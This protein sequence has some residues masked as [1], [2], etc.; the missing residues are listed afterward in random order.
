MSWVIANSVAAG[1]LA[2]LVLLVGRLLRPAPAVMHVLWLFVLL[3][4]ITPPLFEVPINVSWLPGGRVPPVVVPLELDDAMRALPSVA[5]PTAALLSANV[6]PAAATA[7][8]WS[9]ALRL[10]WLIGSV[11]FLGVLAL[12]V[13][14]GR[15]RL[16]ALGPVS[17][18]LQREVEAL[19]QQLG[20]RVPEV[21]D[22]PAAASPCVWSLGRVRLVLPA[23]VLATSSPKGRAAVL[24]HELAHLRRGDHWIAHAELL[25]AVVLWWHPLFWFARSRLRHEAELACDAWAV[26]SVP[27]ATIDYAAVLIETVARPDSAVPGLTVLAAR[28]AARAAFERRLTMIL[29]ENVPCRASRAWW[30]PFASL[31]LG[32]FAVPVVAQQEAKPELRIEVR[33]NGKDVG[34]L[35]AAERRALLQRLL[36]DEAAEAKSAKPV[37]NGKQDPA[38]AKNPEKPGKS[39]KKKAKAVEP[40]DG[41]PSKAEMREMIERGMEEMPAEP[42]EGMPSKAE[43]KALMESGLAEARAE[44]LADKD[45]RQLG[46]T[47]EVVDL[48]DNFGSGK[49]IDGS[50][51]GIIK[52]AMKGA[53]KLVAKE[54]KDDPDLKKLGLASGI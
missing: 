12:G 14:R 26:A 3:K 5:M 20:V 7:L 42:F 28:P 51:D 49:G 52:A 31:G 24:A 48:L 53:G 9:D 2:L 45:L 18:S 37:K 54:L 11:T 46:I 17:P 21:L 15:R 30:L 4:L 39:G 22:D 38:K 47:E 1:V 27:E 36:G 29:N 6:P 25:L 41:M 35:S 32:L 44:L 40:F 43:M 16:Q 19:A 33:V 23:A 13:W 8:S 34:E 50:I 10:L